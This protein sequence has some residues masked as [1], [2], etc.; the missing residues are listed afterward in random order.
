MAEDSWGLEEAAL[1]SP[2]QGN[3]SSGCKWCEGEFL[4]R[5]KVKGKRG[6]GAEEGTCARHSLISSSKGCFPHLAYK[7]IETQ[8]LSNLFR[9]KQLHRCGQR[10]RRE[11]RV[12]SPAATETFKDSS[13]GG[14]CRPGRM[15]R[16]SR[17]E[18][19]TSRDRPEPSFPAEHMSRGLGMQTLRQHSSDQG[20]TG[21]STYPALGE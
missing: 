7:A 13:P 17:Q 9:M 16:R 6:D 11:R 14:S 19:C 1:S 12:D 10:Q 21:R 8:R 20:K 2:L 5:Q 4:H 18:A 3:S 15:V